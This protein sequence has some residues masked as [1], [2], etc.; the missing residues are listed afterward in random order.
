MSDPRSNRATPTVPAEHVGIVVIGRNEGEHLLRAFGSVGPQ[1][2]A[3]VY[4]DS[5]S[6]DDSVALVRE[7]FPEV[8]VVEM[9]AAERPTSPSRGRNEGYAAL[10]RRLP[11]VR[12]V[13][14]LDGDCELHPDWLSTAAEY[15]QA[16]PEVGVVAGRL[17]ERDRDRN[18]FHRLADMEWDQ[19]AGEVNDMGGIMMVRASVWDEAGGQNPDIPAAEERE[20]CWRVID[21]G[22]TVM[23]L[24]DD[25]AVHDIDMSDLREW[26]TRSVRTGHAYAQG[27]W[28]HRDRWHLRQVVSMLAYGAALPG[29]ALG[30]APLTLGLSLSLLS[31]YPRLWRKIEQGRRERGD[32]AEDARLYATANLAGKLAGAVGVAQFF[33]RTLA[34]G[35]GGRRGT[36]GGG[37]RGTPPPGRGIV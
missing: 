3:A 11:D 12:Y 19:P 34:Q 35:R 36:I 21:A 5:A 6:T 23:R 24:A 4:A 1:A 29:A 25:M 15:L 16:H 7:R 30:G 20:F 33:T 31:A 13:Q 18:A 2:G 28:V 32:S 26:W 8:E 27:Y 14:F 10:R 22:H 37:R 17:R 9:S